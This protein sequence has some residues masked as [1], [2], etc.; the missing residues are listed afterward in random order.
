MTHMMKDQIVK[1]SM[2]EIQSNE[3]RSSHTLLGRVITENRMTTID[4]REAVARKH[5][6]AGEGANQ[7][8]RG[9]TWSL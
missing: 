6:L 3:F 5:Y 8:F 1:F 7:G 2:E 9:K 4:L